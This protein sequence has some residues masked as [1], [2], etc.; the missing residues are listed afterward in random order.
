ME[1]TCECSEKPLGPF[2]WSTSWGAQAP[3][4]LSPIRDLKYVPK[5]YGM[6]PCP[7]FGADHVAM[8]LV[9]WGKDQVCVWSWSV[10]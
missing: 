7:C 4:T 9:L 1:V 8:A 6:L 2:T 5:V 10:E 3:E